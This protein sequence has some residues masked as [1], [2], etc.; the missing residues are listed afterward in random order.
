MDAAFHSES[1]VSA[2]LESIIFTLLNW[3]QELPSQT[4]APLIFIRASLLLK[5]I[6]SHRS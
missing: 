1:F 5:T 4:L 3:I 6:Q 2:F